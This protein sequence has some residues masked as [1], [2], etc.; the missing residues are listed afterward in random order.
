MD[1]Q[2]H[3]VDR[4]IDMWIDRVIDRYMDGWIDRQIDRYIH[5]CSKID[6]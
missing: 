4:Q 3:Y 1:R 2:I 6:R 5:T